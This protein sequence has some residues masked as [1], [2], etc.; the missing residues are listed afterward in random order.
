MKTFNRDLKLDNGW[1]FHH[2]KINVYYDTMAQNCKAGGHLGNL[3]LDDNV[4]L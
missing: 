3:Q 1:L 2:G 4:L